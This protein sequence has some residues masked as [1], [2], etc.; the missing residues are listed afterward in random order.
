MKQLDELELMLEK[1]RE[2]I[3]NQRRQVKKLQLKFLKNLSLFCSTEIRNLRFKN[4][5]TDPNFNPKIQLIAERQQ[6]HM[7]QIK[8]QEA[9]R[10]RE[11][12][13]TQPAP[14]PAEVSYTFEYF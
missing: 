7:E 12:Q 3:E 11:V 2:T 1:Q 8:I 10:A 13:R 9:A 6:F 5:F 14:E 4:I